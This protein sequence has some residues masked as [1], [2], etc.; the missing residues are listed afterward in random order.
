MK[1]KIADSVILSSAN[2]VIIGFL[3]GM[4]SWVQFLRGPRELLPLLVLVL[5]F[6]ILPL[7]SLFTVAY[8]ILDLIRPGMRIQAV[9]ALLLFVPT[10]IF[11]ASIRLDI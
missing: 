5:A 2:L 10:A 9:L 4:P 11:L 6:V 7:T 8:V 1:G 3:Y